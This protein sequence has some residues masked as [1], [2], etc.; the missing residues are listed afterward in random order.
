MPATFDEQPKQQ[1]GEPSQ[2]GETNETDFPSA[3][4]CIVK[5]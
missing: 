3:F 2:T 5:E 4:S 1:D